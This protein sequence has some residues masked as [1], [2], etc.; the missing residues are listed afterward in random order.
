MGPP[1]RSTFMQ[2]F[3]GRKDILGLIRK[4]IGDL[5]EGYRQNLALVGS[6]HVGKSAVLQKFLHDMDD[7][8]V[9]PVY[10]DLEGR[11]IHYFVM[12]MVR[13]L[14]YQYAK[15]KGLALQESL[16]DLVDVVR[17]VAPVTAA[18]ALDA[19]H[20]VEKNQVSEA[21]AA[22][23][24]LP[25]ILAQETGLL[26]VIVVDEFHQIDE[27]GIADSFKMLADRITLQ[28]SCLFIITSS[29]EDKARKILAERLTLLFGNFEIVHVLP[30]DL[31]SSGE[32][33]ES[34]M[35]GLRMG[36]YLRNFLADFTGG[37]PLYLD[38]LLQEVSN[39]SAIYKQPEA[40]APMVV[41]AVENLVFSRWGALSRHFELMVDRI[42]GGRLNRPVMDILFAMVNGTHKVKDLV[43]ILGVK[44]AQVT[45]KLNFLIEEDIVERNGTYV[46]VKDKLFRYWIKYVFQRRIKSVDL[47]QGR[48]MRDFKE[49]LTRAVSQFQV[50]ARKD[51]S[52][53]MTELV[54]CFSNELLTLRGHLYR[55]PVFTQIRPLKIKARGGNSFDVLEAKSEDGVWLLVLRK[56]PVGEADIH[57]VAEEARKMGVRPR[58]CV[59]VALSELDD[60]AKLK[61]LEERMWIW[62]ESELN[63][64]M[65]LYD[66]PYIVP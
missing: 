31:K 14:L 8:A 33:I 57:F 28:K 34:R 36:L 37:R 25:D 52:T 2:Y 7:H 15:A 22:A 17:G 18:A 63:S 42:C 38:L 35:G 6:R 10:L 45:Q 43:D 59:I 49:E 12:K 26:S 16:P 47:E 3:Y 44:Q 27:F 39:L 62:N 20:L 30:F 65:N 66:Q 5:K 51:F 46:H 64:L 4:R 54:S 11:D 41:Q 13:G 1:L 50:T 56:D 29:F 23:L 53:R 19:A 24:R 61:A 32:F 9:I 55:L 60:A 58:R 40:Y 48:Q 21:Y